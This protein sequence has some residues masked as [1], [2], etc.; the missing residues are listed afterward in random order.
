MLEEVRSWSKASML[1][2]YGV[3]I[4]GPYLEDYD[5]TKFP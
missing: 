1:D 2:R 4:G 5:I 3:R